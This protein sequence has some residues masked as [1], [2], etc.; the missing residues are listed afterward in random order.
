MKAWLLLLMCAPALAQDVDAGRSLAATCANCHGT[1]GRPRGQALAPLAGMKAEAMLA[2]LA[3]YR[4]GARAGTVMPQIVKGYT[5]A[6]LRL[7]AAYFATQ[8]KP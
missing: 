8:A 1:D 7:V 2:L 5:E 3:E 6:Q 4:R